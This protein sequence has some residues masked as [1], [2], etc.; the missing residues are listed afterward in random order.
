[1]PRIFLAT[2]WELE[3]EQ[4]QFHDIVSRFCEQSGMAQG[5]LY[6]PVVFKSMPDKR[7]FQYAVEQNIRACRHYILAVTEDWGPKERNF[8]K[9]YHLAL[10][11]MGDPEAEMK[12]VTLLAKREPW[13]EAPQLAEG[14]PAPDAV[15]STTAEFEEI[16]MGLMRGWLAEM[17]A[18]PVPL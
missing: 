9:D 14:M 7:P 11:L 5:V 17:S 15:Y 13:Q 8:R 2:P 1:M 12:T 16:L 18:E 10:V 6:V 3:P 4:L